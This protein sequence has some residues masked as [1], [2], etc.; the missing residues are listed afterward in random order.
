M[1]LFIKDF[2]FN[3]K[4]LHRT[5]NVG[6][7]LIATIPLSMVGLVLHELAHAYTTKF[8]GRAIK[9]F[10][11]GWYWLGPVAFCDTSDMW[12]SPIK[13]RIAV[14]AAGLYVHILIAGISSILLN[15]VINPYIA[16]FFW[17]FALFN[18]L[19]VF[20]NLNPIIELD[21]YYLLMN[22]LQKENL[23]ESAITWLIRDFSRDWKKKST[24]IA[25][26]AE[27]IYWLFSFFF[28]I[29]ETIIPYFMMKYIL[30]GLF[31]I[32]NPIYSIMISLLVFV[33]S[34]VAILAE[35]RKNQR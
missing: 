1:L 25:H 30:S 18:Y 17:L 10:G 7:I 14:D 6:W 23:K 3:L 32:T 20:Y 11:I 15:F 8:F 12:L 5:P 9:S 34:S 22:F 29:L 24:Y 21:G 27:L 35:I 13:Q 26:K 28:L 31:G 33:F 16:L 19:A 2:S 4:L